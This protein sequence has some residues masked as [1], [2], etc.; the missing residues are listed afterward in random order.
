MSSIERDTTKCLGIGSTHLAIIGSEELQHPGD[1][2]RC[3]VEAG[4]QSITHLH[5]LS[6]VVTIPV[7]ERSDGLE[8]G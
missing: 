7:E 5:V 2:N 3:R 1:R 6:M 4:K 8:G